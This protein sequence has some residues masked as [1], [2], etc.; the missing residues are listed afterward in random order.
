MTI[1]SGGTITTLPFSQ[2]EI[3]CP[4]RLCIKRVS[5]TAACRM[6]SMASACSTK[7]TLAK[8]TACFTLT[9]PSLSAT[10]PAERQ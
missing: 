8:V 4:S 1:S 9:V 3:E 7:F 10:S 2:I 6:R 5:R